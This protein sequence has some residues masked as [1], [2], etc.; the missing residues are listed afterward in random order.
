[1]KKVLFTIALVLSTVISSY[2]Q[3]KDYNRFYASFNMGSYSLK[4][5]GDTR[6]SEIKEATAGLNSFGV[7]GVN[8]G[9]AHAISLSKTTPLFLELGLEA[10]YSAGSEKVPGTTAD[11]NVK[12]L[13]LQVPLN[14]TYRIPVTEKF[15]IAPFVGANFK[16]NIIGNA[17]VSVNDYNSEAISFFNEDDMSAMSSITSGRTETANR[18]QIGMNAGVNFIIANKFSIGYRFQPDFMNYFGYDIKLKS[19]DGGVKLTSTNHYISL[20]LIF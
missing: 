5:M 14:F 8:M 4:G 12:M 16:V 9:Y 11:I 18:F 6:D 17:S 3:N 13:N 15:A 7:I 10:N 20:G 1:M 2:A 19:Y